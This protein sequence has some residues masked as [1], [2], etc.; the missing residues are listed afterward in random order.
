M[1]W[2]DGE[3]KDR[4]FIGADRYNI[5][6]IT[7]QVAL[8]TARGALT[9]RIPEDHKNLSRWWAAVTRRPSARA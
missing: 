5:A 4:E 1:R 6:D 2:L 9:L 7:T 8:L 3:L